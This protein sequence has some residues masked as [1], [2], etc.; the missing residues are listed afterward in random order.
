MEAQVAP[1]KPEGVA[2]TEPVDEFVELLSM[3]FLYEQGRF[4]GLLGR[5][6]LAVVILVILGSLLFTYPA[7]FDSFI[8]SKIAPAGPTA[9]CEDISQLLRTAVWWEMVF[10]GIAILFLGSAIFSY[11]VAEATKTRLESFAEDHRN[12]LKT[13]GDAT[14]IRLRNNMREL[15]TLVTRDGY[16]RI[17]WHPIQIGK[18]LQRIVSDIGYQTSG[19]S[20]PALINALAST[21]PGGI[22]GMLSFIFFCG[23]LLTKAIPVIYG[24]PALNPCGV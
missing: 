13:K 4:M 22:M 21:F 9:N 5:S 10:E 15:Y 24:S 20:L 14:K 3:T 19:I 18:L 8:A 6:L 7:F 23:A 12:R 17:I 16:L 2:S 11:E 1:P